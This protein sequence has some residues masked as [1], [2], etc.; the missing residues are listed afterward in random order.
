MATKKSNKKPKKV[1][2]RTINPN[3][4][5]IE[6]A[7]A[8]GVFWLGVVLTRN[9]IDPWE[10]SL[11]VFIYSWPEWLTPLFLVITQFGNIT[12]LMLL[13]I[14]AFLFQKYTLVI[15][16]LMSGS[17][18]Y[19]LTGVA[20]DL[21]GRARPAD[22]IT[23]IAYRDFIRG[24]GFP[25]GH[26]ALATAFAFTIGY[27]VPRKYHFITPLI[28]VG[29]GLSRVY[30]GAHAPLDLLGGFA[31]GWLAAELFRFV[32]VKAVKL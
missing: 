2:K 5:R 13:S 15:R 10:R 9:T 1:S 7:L 23:D 17:L 30:L 20:K 14:I 4:L 31:I 12:L 19:L 24:P 8:I 22:L 26:M 29:V 27:F 6:V 25:S 3:I 11:F 16:L 18:A 21:V 28:I 32:E